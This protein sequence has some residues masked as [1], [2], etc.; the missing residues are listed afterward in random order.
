M[1]REIPWEGFFRAAPVYVPSARPGCTAWVTVF[2]RP[3]GDIGLS[4]D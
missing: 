1:A 3:D 4:F 2:T